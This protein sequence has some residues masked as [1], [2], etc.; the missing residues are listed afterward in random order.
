MLLLRCSCLR[1]EFI[2]SELD[3]NQKILT[4]FI[5]DELGTRQIHVYSI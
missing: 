3:P 5:D 2:P 4:I 1:A